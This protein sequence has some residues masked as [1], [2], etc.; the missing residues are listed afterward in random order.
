MDEEVL[1]DPDDYTGI[2]YLQG[3]RKWQTK[4]GE[5]HTTTKFTCKYM[6]E[7][8]IAGKLIQME[9]NTGAVVSVIPENWY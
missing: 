7:A 9:L 8:S 5:I 4:P 1:D 2:A 3:D 6:V